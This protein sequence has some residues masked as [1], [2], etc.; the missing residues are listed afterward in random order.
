MKYCSRDE[1]ASRYRL[2]LDFKVST[3]NYPSFKPL[4]CIARRNILKLSTLPA[5]SIYRLLSATII[6]LIQPKYCH[7]HVWK[8]RIICIEEDLKY[9]KWTHFSEASAPLYVRKKAIRL[10][11]HLLCSWSWHFY[12]AILEHL[13][14]GFHSFWISIFYG[15]W[16]VYTLF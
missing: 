14:S 13:I 11:F 2:H 16:I 4:L 7:G 10:N 1:Y 5:L 8:N 15:L 12:K 3:A 9:R 6:S